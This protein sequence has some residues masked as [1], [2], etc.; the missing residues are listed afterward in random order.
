MASRQVFR[1]QKIISQ[2]I[3]RR[4]NTK[5]SIQSK[6]EMLVNGTEKS[7]S[8]HRVRRLRISVRSDFCWGG[9]RGGIVLF[10]NGV[11]CCIPITISIFR[12]LVS[13]K[14]LFKRLFVSK[15]NTI[16]QDVV[17]FSQLTLNTPT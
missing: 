11:H 8:D 5:F 12:Y 13:A 16:I 15:S 10:C 7:L 9:G 14:I 4:C 2:E 1:I 6:R 3:L 17:R